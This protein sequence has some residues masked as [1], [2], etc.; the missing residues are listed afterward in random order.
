MDRNLSK[1]GPEVEISGEVLR[2][3]RRHARGSLEEEVCGVLIG[4]HAPNGVRVD[5]SIPGV[6]AGQGTAHVTFTHETWEHIY[7]IKDEKY[8]DDKI[9]GWYHSHPGFGIFL[10]DHDIFVHE[11]FFSGPEQIAWVYDPHSD[12]EGC[13]G[14]AEGRIQRLNKI[15]STFEKN[16]APSDDKMRIEPRTAATPET[17]RAEA[18]SGGARGRSRWVAATK[19]ALAFVLGCVLTI[20]ILLLL[21]PSGGAIV[22]DSQGRPVLILAPL[23]G[24]ISR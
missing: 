19:Y 18:P 2:R 12:E 15:V 8:P 3:V 6:G 4:R 14:W 24:E 11:N 22:L 7:K 23:K 17:L 20:G 16:D 13:F 1:R 21:L 9:V 10:S 5:A